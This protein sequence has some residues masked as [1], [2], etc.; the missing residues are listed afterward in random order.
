MI[1]NLE[2]SEVTLY[3]SISFASD[4]FLQLAGSC[5]VNSL[6]G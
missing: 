5:N 2:F 6:K 1:K 3:V 4:D